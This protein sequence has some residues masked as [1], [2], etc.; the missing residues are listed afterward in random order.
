MQ[1]DAK[2]PKTIETHNDE[3]TQQA[4]SEPME[5]HWVK[6]PQYVRKGKG[7]MYGAA[8][9][10]ASMVSNGAENPLIDNHPAAAG[11]VPNG[12]GGIANHAMAEHNGVELGN[13]PE[14]T[15]QKERTNN[16][17][18]Q[19]QQ[20]GSAGEDSEFGTQ[21]SLQGFQEY[22]I[23]VANEDA[24]CGYDAHAVSK[25]WCNIAYACMQ[26]WKRVYFPM[27]FL[28][29]L[30]GA[31]ITNMKGMV[32]GNIL[33]LT[34]DEDSYAPFLG[35][36]RSI[37][38]V[39]LIPATQLATSYCID[40]GNSLEYVTKDYYD[41]GLIYAWAKEQYQTFT[42][43]QQGK[44]I[45]NLPN[46]K[47]APYGGH[48]SGMP[49]SQGIMEQMSALDQALAELANEMFHLLT[50]ATVVVNVFQGTTICYLFLLGPLAAA[51]YAWPTVGRDLFRHNFA[52]WLDAV[53][54]TSLWKFWWNVV[55]ICMTVR[56][57]S[58]NVDPYN[59]YEIYWLVAFM[60]ILLVVP[61]NPF[62]FRAGE[63]VGFILQ[64]AEGV[65]AKAAQGGKSAGGGG[66]TAKGS[67]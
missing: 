54:M 23:N 28:F 43:D 44:L 56:L 13:E 41:T 29:L 57:Q 33:T 31:I 51:F 34:M 48:F 65:A 60:A 62:D 7:Q 15:S 19:G 40:I 58:E 8:F 49:K 12:A 30:P 26:M 32:A 38:A 5:D 66:K 63:I 53:V 35:I 21:Y 37:V 61:F 64:K 36:C 4:G 46:V 67:G 45:Q 3:G 20:A 47:Q 16:H 39:F 50:I 52:N 6:S 42:P 1:Q 25:Q 17:Q 14:Q 59:P 22:L 9:T 2:M 55:L 18:K 11:E 10:N 27:A 24:G